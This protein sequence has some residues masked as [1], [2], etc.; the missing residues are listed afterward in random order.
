[1]VSLYNKLSLVHFNCIY[2]YIYTNS[3][4]MTATP[5]KFK[6]ATI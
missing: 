2:Y 4:K 6:L 5:N 1:M 3:T